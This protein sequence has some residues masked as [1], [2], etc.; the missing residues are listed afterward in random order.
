M[1]F[2]IPKV[3]LPSCPIP[4]RETT[5][6]KMTSREPCY[7]GLAPRPALDHDDGMGIGGGPSM[8]IGL[9]AHPG[10]PPLP[11]AA[12]RSIGTGD[13]EAAPSTGTDESD[14]AVSLSTTQKPSRHCYR[15]YSSRHSSNIGTPIP[16]NLY[17]SPR[18][19]TTKPAS[20]TPPPRRKRRPVPATRRRRRRSRRRYRLHP[21]PRRRPAG[22]EEE[23]RRRSHSHR[24]SQAERALDE[25]DAGQCN[26]GKE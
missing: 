24:C 12:A 25:D 22:W 15:A 9:A 5:L 7:R 23:G 17:A 6:T 4:I 21:P 3:G 11:A 26:H 14:D 2:I 20:R 13:P 1:P 18:S 10:G 19:E 8:A 16:P